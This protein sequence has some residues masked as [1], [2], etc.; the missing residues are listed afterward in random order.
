M[1]ITAETDEDSVPADTSTSLSLAIGVPVDGAVNTLGDHDWF[2]VE[3]LAGKRYQ[4]TMDG[5]AFGSYG[6]LI[7]PLVRLHD[8]SGVQIAEN[9]DI[10]AGVLRNAR[11]NWISPTSGRYYVNA[12]A[13]NDEYSGGFRLAITEF[14]P[15]TYTLDQIADFLTSG[16]WG[17]G[18][19][20]WNTSIDNVITYNVTQLTSEGQ[21]LAR[22]AF[23]AWANVTNL[24]FQEVTSGGDIPFDDN[25]S[26]AF[27]G[28]SWQDGFITSM[29]V[30]IS[31]AWLA[32]Y[33]TTIDSYSF[34]TYVHEIGHAL[35]LGHAGPYNQTA[36]YGLDNMYQNDVWSYTIMSYFN[37]TRASFGSYRVVMGPSLADIVAAHNFYGANT[38]FNSND[39][40]YGRNGTAGSLFDFAN[41]ATVPAF[42]VYDTGGADTLDASGYSANQTINL[43]AEAFSSIG[44]LTNNITI[45]RGV[46]IEAAIGGDGADSII[47]NASNNIL[48]GNAGADTLIGGTGSDSLDGGAG[49]DLLMADGFGVMIDGG[50]GDDVILLGGAQLADILALFS[51]SS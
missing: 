42:T 6:A 7:D 23:E 15:P 47:G 35:G 39:N 50:E 3:V 32:S 10:R 43:N 33:G 29:G 1:E 13:Y 21:V 45:A 27:A 2:A 5:V 49:N 16:Y 11:L 40:V 8:A 37:Q 17:N 24:L 25:V 9:D 20:R 36:T 34:Q 46:V 22:A 44:S 30:N 12:G 31:T 26:G 48:M 28:G 18:S 14:N 51:L 4:I 41:Y 38:T 19:H